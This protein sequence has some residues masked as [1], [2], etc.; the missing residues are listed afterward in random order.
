MKAKIAGPKATGDANGC[1]V[2]CRA[3]GGDDPKAVRVLSV[4]GLKV[5]TVWKFCE[6]EDAEMGDLAT[7]RCGSVTFPLPRVHRSKLPTGLKRRLEDA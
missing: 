4:D 7:D 5:K 2:L 3:R 6:S 1:S